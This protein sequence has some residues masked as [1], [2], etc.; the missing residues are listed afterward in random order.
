MQIQ[1]LIIFSR[2][3][4]RREL[5]FNLNGVS[6][7][8]GDSATGKSSLIEIVDYCLGSGECRVPDGVIRDKVSWYALRLVSEANGQLFVARRGPETG[9]KSTHQFVLLFGK[10][11]AIPDL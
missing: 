2:D 6:I 10:E 8:A 9:A 5:T 1:S 3:G 11:V 7:I 4:R